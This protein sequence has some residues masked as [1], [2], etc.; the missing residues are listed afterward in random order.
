MN[1]L[2][3]PDNPIEE[4]AEEIV[5]LYDQGH[6]VIVY[7]NPQYANPQFIDD[8]FFYKEVL[9]LLD[10]DMKCSF[11]HWAGLE[12]SRVATV[13]RPQL[14]DINYVSKETLFEGVEEKNHVEK[15]K[16]IVD[17]FQCKAGRIV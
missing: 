1:V 13:L 15:V 7:I 17:F 9:D 16:K 11:L 10:S 4:M 6:R 8:L 2:G 3:Y 5:S 14:V 12:I